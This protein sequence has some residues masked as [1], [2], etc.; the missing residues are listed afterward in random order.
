[1]SPIIIL[2]AKFAMPQWTREKLVFGINVTINLLRSLYFLVKYIPQSHEPQYSQ[3]V[4]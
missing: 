2:V 4:L 1:M 3:A